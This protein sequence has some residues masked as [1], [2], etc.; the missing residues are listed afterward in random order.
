MKGQTCV[1]VLHQLLPA[2]T[3]SGK[4]A[5]KGQIH[6]GLLHC[7][8]MLPVHDLVCFSWRGP[9]CNDAALGMCMCSACMAHI[10]MTALLH[11]AF[12]LYPCICKQV[13][14]CKGVVPSDM[15]TLQAPP[16]LSTSSNNKLLRA[17]FQQQKLPSQMQTW[18][19]SRLLS[20]LF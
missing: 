20:T 11:V 18:M 9:T 13:L 3:T 1:N 12:L 16:A 17:D 10:A 6:C 7:E 15:C 4:A 19:S 5:L 2:V 14:A 8:I